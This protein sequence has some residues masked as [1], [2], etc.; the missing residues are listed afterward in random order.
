MST[1]VASPPAESDAG[2]APAPRP[3]VRPH[4]V[5]IG[6][7]VFAGLFTMASGLM[8]LFTGWHDDSPI[9]RE[10]FSGVPDP[11]IVAFYTVTPVL[12]VYVAYL[13][14]L[15]VR[16]WERGTPDNRR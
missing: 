11:L 1:T 10:V 16:N 4:Q 15:R 3:P 6:L 14:S 9:A 8:P 2:A 7:G 5:V 13:F 12:L